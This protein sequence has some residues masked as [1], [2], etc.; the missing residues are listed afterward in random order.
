MHRR[1]IWSSGIIAAGLACVLGANARAQEISTAE[2]AE[3]RTA[4]MTK[5]SDGIVLLHAKSGPKD[6]EQPS[7]I[8]DATF[9][10]F[11]G[12]VNQPSAI[13]VLDG[14]ANQTHLFIPPPPVSFGFA[15]QNLMLAPSAQT[16]D[17][18]GLDTVQPWD[19]LSSYLRRRIDNGV[20]RFYVDESRRPEMPGAPTEMWPIAGEKELWRRSLAH[21]FP[22]VVIESARG[23]I[24]EL[25]W[26]KSAAE[27]EILRRNAQITTHALLAGIRQI[28]PGATQRETEAAVISGCIE[29][30]GEG[31][32]FWPWTMSGP[33]AHVDQLVR[34]FFDYSHL[35]R[36]MIAG[37]LVRVD[38][39]CTAN[40]YGGDV[41]RTIPVAGRFTPGQAETWDL[42]ISA[43]R[44]GMEAL[45]P[46]VTVAGV[47]AVSRAEVERLAGGMQT[48][49]GRAAATFLLSERGMSVWSIHGV[50]IDSGETP[51]DMLVEGAVIAFEPMFEI[52]DDAFYL[53]DM[54]VVMANGYEVLS[55]GLPYTAQEIE[56]VMAQG[57]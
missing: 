44:K 52:G 43:Y 29:A 46:G 15:V 14:P 33:N 31:P 6:M 8:Q 41:G 28:R 16:A 10:Y 36:T 24:Q 27:V 51:L 9:L 32:S 23:A 25:R 30:G 34:A 57:R 45:R 49:Q 35:N 1:F 40:S 47:M 7:W 50:G 38:V 2:L 5:T 3:R 17:R 22:D 37:E 55:E 4:L 21:A 13:L 20:G 53:E 54:I 12:L 42:L 18:L 56:E 48:Q 39:G 11:T 26:K 19:Q